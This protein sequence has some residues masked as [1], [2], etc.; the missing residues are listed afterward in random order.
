MHLFRF[1]EKIQKLENRISELESEIQSR[2]EEIEKLQEEKIELERKIE[3]LKRKIEN[4]GSELFKKEILNVHAP[5]VKEMFERGCY[6]FEEFIKWREKENLKDLE[7]IENELEEV[8]RT[9]LVILDGDYD[10]CMAASFLYYYLFL[11]HE[12]PNFYFPISEKHLYE[13]TPQLV[14]RT[15]KQKIFLLDFH[16]P[17]D[18]KKREKFLETI[19][20]LK[21]LYFITHHHLTPR[22]IKIIGDKLIYSEDLSTS[23]LVRDFLKVKGIYS[24]TIER[25]TFLFSLLRGDIKDVEP[26]EIIRVVKEFNLISHSLSYSPFDFKF[27]TRI[28]HLLAFNIPLEGDPEIMRRA[29]LG[30]MIL[31]YLKRRGYEKIRKISK[32]L[33]IF[34]TSYK[35]TKWMK[36]VAEKISKENKVI[37]L[38]VTSVGRRV[39][40]IGENPFPEMNIG[41]IF[42]ESSKDFGYGGGYEKVGNA[43]IDKDKFQFFLSKIEEEIKNYIKK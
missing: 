24:K 39:K 19:S 1:K 2:D 31:N 13:L 28:I 16:L 5:L 14:W 21:N 42:R 25:N 4:L 38:G 18:Q 10:G 29:A 11:I 43:L 12:A 6:S 35:N 23:E 15:P 17:Y 41:R 30:K 33:W 20:K 40:V 3:S 9:P 34:P 22:E 26:K 32:N 27:A 8:R 7:R 36:Y 37:C